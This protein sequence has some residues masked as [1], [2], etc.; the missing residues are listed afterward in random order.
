MSRKIYSYD[1]L[2]ALIAAAALSCSAAQAESLFD[3]PNAPVQRQ[4]GPQY[5]PTVEQKDPNADIDPRLQRQ[6]V[7]YAG[8][9]NSGH[10]HHR[11]PEHVPLLRA[12]QRKVDP[13]R[14]RRR[15]RRVHWSG[16]KSIARKAEWPDWYPPVEMIH[17]SLICR[18]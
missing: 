17:A 16:V 9:E 14:H 3:F 13:L 1:S 2:T 8:H 6:I 4:I 5:A 10:D 7:N 12:W 11:Y 15:P 18:A